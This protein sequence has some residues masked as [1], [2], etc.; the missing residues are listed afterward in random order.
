MSIG[1]LLVALTLTSLITGIIVVGND[2]DSGIFYRLFQLF[3]LDF[4]RNVPTWF[5]SSLLTIIA[6]LLLLVAYYSKILERQYIAHWLF[7]SF[8]FFGLSMDEF[9]Q[10]HEQ[11][12]RPTRSM[13]NT[14]GLLYNAWIIPAGIIVFII[15]LMYLRFILNLPRSTQRLFLIAGFLYTGAVFGAEAIGG[16]YYS[17]TMRSLDTDYDIGYL[18]ITNIEELL[19]MSGL[20][21][22]LYG[23]FQHI[24]EMPLAVEAESVRPERKREQAAVPAP[25]WRKEKV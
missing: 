24:H 12:I 13:L 25:I 8:I 15:G 7:L 19:E 9:I 2:I 17:E 18:L 1:T 4:E 16:Y 21:I 6:L 14:S 23:L 10:F 22:F 20:T 5:S 11:I 3:N